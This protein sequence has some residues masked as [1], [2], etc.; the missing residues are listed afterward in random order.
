M[1][2]RNKAGLYV[3]MLTISGGALP[4]PHDHTE[5]KDGARMATVLAENL[6]RISGGWANNLTVSTGQLQ[7]H[8]IRLYQGL[9]VT[10]VGFWHAAGTLTSGQTHGWF[11]LYDTS[12]N[13][14]R[15][16]IDQLTVVTNT[17][18][19]ANAANV[20]AVDSIPVTAGARVASS[21]VTLT[22]P[23]LKESLTSLV[24][25][26]DSIVVSNANVAAYNGTWTVVTVSATQITYDCGASAT[27]SLV[28][29]FP[30]VQLAA[31]KRIYNV[32]A[33]G[34][35]LLGFMVAATT[36]P[37]CL[38]VVTVAALNN[39]APVTSV[40]STGALTGTAPSP[41]GA[42]TGKGATPYGFVS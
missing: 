40:T 18:G 29:P 4:A 8:A 7:L 38:A 36:T 41:A 14:I 35:Y 21:T 24:V 10:N 11:A 2:R 16:S 5:L 9:P 17:F 19:T 1:W 26:G 37:N 25:A 3:P 33:N 13:L 39:A 22:V 27:D 12:L 34:L 28:A 32:P 15:Q 23:T 30:T 20:L 42:T 6:S 31:G